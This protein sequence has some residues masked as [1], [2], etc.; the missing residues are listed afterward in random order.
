MARPA[1]RYA[2]M[3]DLVT[4]VF[5]EIEPILWNFMWKE[6]DGQLDEIIEALFFLYLTR[7]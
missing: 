4:L 3:E 1:K 5:E 2:V 6:F 7:S